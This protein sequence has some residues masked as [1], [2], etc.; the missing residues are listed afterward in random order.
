MANALGELP[1][2]STAMQRGEVL[3]SKVR[4][5]TR[6][7][8]ARNEEE[9]LFFARAATAA[10]VEKFVRGWRLVDQQEELDEANRLHMSR[11]LQ[12]WSEEDG[13]VVVRGRLEPEAGR[14]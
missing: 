8:T 7:V 12:V 14:R 4:A 9:L 1:L 11:S 3:Y 2:M 10:H 13:M 6:V 5:L